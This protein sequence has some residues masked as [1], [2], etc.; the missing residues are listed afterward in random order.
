VKLFQGVTPK[1]EISSSL[2][3]YMWFYLQCPTVSA[4]TCYGVH[5]SFS[6][7]ILRARNL[8][9]YSSHSF[10]VTN[11]ILTD[12]HKNF[13]PVQNA[14]RNE[15]ANSFWY[16]T[17]VN[18]VSSSVRSWICTAYWRL[19]IVLMHAFQLSSKRN[20]KLWYCK[21]LNCAVSCNSLRC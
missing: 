9:T 13:R 15:L 3:P 16:P 10:C 2:T 7:H 1:S 19:L 11:L 8:I 21:D 14:K 4:E 12:Q 17:Y 6:Y 20:T 5:Y 18:H